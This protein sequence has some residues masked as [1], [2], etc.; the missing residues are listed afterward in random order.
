MV[1]KAKL[2]IGVKDTS[3]VMNVKV[4]EENLKHT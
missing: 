4:V 2:S 3:L 1:E